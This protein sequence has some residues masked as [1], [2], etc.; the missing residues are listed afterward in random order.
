MTAYRFKGLLQKEGWISPAYVQV[1]DKGN[2]I[3]IADKAVATVTYKR[4]N[5]FAIPGLQNA[6]SHAFQY[7]MVGLTERHVTQGQQDNFWGWR[8]AMYQFCLLYTSPSP[9]DRTRSRMPSSA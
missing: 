9:R 4:V 1:D 3:A 2:I 8:K 5:G 7:A 6:H